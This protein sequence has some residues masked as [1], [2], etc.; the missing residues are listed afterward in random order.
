MKLR[1]IGATFAALVAL[2]AGPLPGAGGTTTAAGRG[3]HDDPVVRTLTT[4]AAPGC[5]SG[6]G[7]GSTIGPDGALYVT[8]GPG[9]RVLRIDPDTGA[10]TTFASGLPQA[11]PAVG[12]GGAADVIFVGRTAYVAVTLVGPDFGQPDV[13]S[14]LYRID[15]DGDP[16][17]VADVGAWSAANPSDTDYFVPSGVAYSLERYRGR[18]LVADGHHNRVLSVSRQGD[19]SEL[20]AFGN[21]VPTGLEVKRGAVYLAQAGPVPHEPQ[22]GKIIRFR[23]DGP[24]VEVASGGPL[25]VDVEAG[26]RHR[27]YALSQ[28]VWDLPDVPENAGAPASPDTGALM[29]AT[30]G[31]DLVP[32]V[33]GLD[34]P[35]SV[36][37]RGGTAWV[38]TLTG[39]VLRID[40]L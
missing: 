7:S 37:I 29:V 13:V 18:L 34:R 21:V 27:L 17:A 31:G 9:G 15:R 12:I 16:V 3:H 40:G 25:L 22:D 10:T 30:R 6:C 5:T 4:F 11:L 38:V 1:R 19:I 2:V 39:T 24:T 28:G 8:D 32:L 33:E 35:T 14:G 23:A 20:Q 26:H 36:E